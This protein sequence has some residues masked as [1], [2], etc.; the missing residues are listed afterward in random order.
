MREAAVTTKMTSR[1]FYSNN[2]K[3][4]CTCDN[5]MH[6][7]NIIVYYIQQYLKEILYIFISTFQLYVEYEVD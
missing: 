2:E 4:L 1:D 7:F 5:Q 3:S 6:L